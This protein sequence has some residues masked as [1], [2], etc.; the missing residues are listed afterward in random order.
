MSKGTIDK[1]TLLDKVGNGMSLDANVRINLF[2]MGRMGYDGIFRTFG[3]SI[4]MD[5]AGYI[6]K[7]VFDCLKD[8]ENKDYKIENTGIKT[9]AYLEIAAGASRKVDKTFSMG[10]KAKLL[11]GLMNADL[12]VDDIT[13][14]TNG[15]TSWTANGK[16]QMRVSGLK[17]KT[18]T[19]D[20]KV[21]PGRYEQV[22]GIKIGDIGVH[23]VGV[24]VDGGVVLKPNNNLE[25]SAAITD[26]GFMAWIKSQKAE[27]S[28][29]EF[30]FNGFQDIEI[31]KDNDNSLKTQWNSMRD[32]IMELAHLEEK[33]NS[34]FMDML[35]ATINIGALYKFDDDNRCKIG[36]LYTGRIDEKY[37]W[38][39]T[40]INAMAKPFARTNLEVCVSPYYSTFGLGVGAMINYMSNG[41]NIYLA[42]DRLF[43]TVNPQ[44]IPT[45]LNGALHIGVAISIK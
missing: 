23:G 13:L 31:E 16:A 43:T 15:E 20:Y 22:S 14:N 33:G 26:L 29:K 32:D 7:G 44:M 2:S 28:G 41:F 36:A 38:W 19:K 1:N 8:I 11:I 30:N 37:S 27:N 12:N 6:S 18:E 34:T 25:L 45:S 42:S 4:R 17:Y 10:G 5:G 39:E 9:S 21:R 24:A 35:G 40:R 3:L